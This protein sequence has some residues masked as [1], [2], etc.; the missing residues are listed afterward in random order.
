MKKIK[1][2]VVHCSATKE[3][4]NFTAIDI[5]Q[6]HLKR[7]WSGIGYH[8]VVLIDGSVEKG[9]PDF[10]KGAHVKDVNEE[11]LGICYIGGLDKNGK[12]KDT[13]TDA[14][15]KGLLCLIEALKK[16]YP[17]ALVSGHRDFSKDL[18]KNGIIDPFERM[19]ECPCF[20]AKIE[21]KNV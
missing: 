5:H 14:Q 10:W 6:W 4:E 16:D 18:N 20:D 11:S 2:I 19:K 15:K 17:K 21:Y 7:G 1:H 8:Y 3:D 13:R 12:A 9:R